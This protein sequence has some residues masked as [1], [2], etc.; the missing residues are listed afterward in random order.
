MIALQI[1]P[2]PRQ[3]DYESDTDVYSRSLRDA[4]RAP[5]VVSGFVLRLLRIKGPECKSLIGGLG[6][7]D[8]EWHFTPFSVSRG[9][10]RRGTFEF[11]LTDFSSSS[12]GFFRIRSIVPRV[13]SANPYLCSYDYERSVQYAPEAYV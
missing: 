8:P 6:I 1:T 9:E 5:P 10:S 12:L 4:L 3:N 2:A 13:H 7:D 11:D